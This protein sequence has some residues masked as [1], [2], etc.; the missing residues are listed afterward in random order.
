MSATAK[1][2]VGGMIAAGLLLTLLVALTPQH[3]SAGPGIWATFAALTLLATAS[4]LFKVEA[5]N[6]VLFYTTP[7]FLFAGVLLLPPVLIVLLVIIPY[8]VAWAKERLSNSPHYRAW[9]LQPFNMAMNSITGLVSYCLYT[10]LCMGLSG[11]AAT[12]GAIAGIAAAL[13]YVLIN[14]IILS[15]ALVLA[16]DI[17]WRETSLHNI[18][19]LLNDVVLN[20]LGL[21]VATLWGNHTLLLIP[22]LAPVVLMYQ[23]LMIPQLKHM[24][25][26]DS[27]TGLA[28]AGH[29]T[30]LFTAELHRATRFSRPLAV[31]MADLDL[32]RHVN[33]TYGHLAGDAVLA[34]IGQILRDTI[35]E[36]DIGGRFGGEEF[37]IVAPETDAEEAV[38]LAERLR[39]AVAEAHFAVPTSSQPL[40]VTM[41]LGVACY[42][43]DGTSTDELIFAADMAVYAAKT[44]GRN[45]VVRTSD[46]TWDQRVMQ[47]PPQ[48][49]GSMSQQSVTGYPA[50]PPIAVVPRNVGLADAP[51]SNE[52]AIPAVKTTD[53]A[54][55]QQTPTA[56]SGRHEHSRR[57][58]QRLS[59]LIPQPAIA[60]VTTLFA[61]LAAW[62]ALRGP[63]DWLGDRSIG[64]PLEAAAL[65]AAIV[66]AYQYPIHIRLHMKV[67]LS[68]MVY[69]WMAVLLPLPLAITAAALGTLAGE[70]S[71][72]TQRT[73][74]PSDI[75]TAASRWLL[76]VLLGNL[77]VHCNGG[78][79][80][81]VIL[82]AGAGLAL[83][84]GDCLTLP[85]IL[86]PITGEQPLRV[87]RTLVRETA[88]ADGIQYLLGF[89]GVL[90]SEQ[91]SWALVLF[92]VP[93]AL[94]Y[95][96][97]THLHN[98]QDSTHRL[99][100]CMA[101]TVDLR[102]PCTGGHSR[103]VETYCQRILG[104]LGICGPDKELIL[105]AARV[106]DIG[107]I[108]IPDSIL[109]KPGALT[110]TEFNMMKTHPGRGAE[111]LARHQDFVR[112]VA[113]VRHHHEAWNGSGYPHGLK[114]VAIPFGARVL[115]VAD[116]FDAMTS[117]RPYR[118]GMS[119]ARAASILRQGR[120]Q[121]WDP[122]IVDAL[123]RSTV[124]EL[125]NGEEQLSAVPSSLLP[126]RSVS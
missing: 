71:V 106:H 28:N 48:A 117:D 25:A 30:S 47:P 111:V 60:L 20:C 23:A 53:R 87:L 1:A 107:K 16:R 24:A 26:I 125:A 35:R 4:Q 51:E 62:S 18:S 43:V 32:L 21:I 121:Q 13:A 49:N 94:V 90:V 15:L 42:P 76:I 83:W 55:Q 8:L 63:V 29:F 123:L 108:G 66:V 79:R 105:S 31:I 57:I 12:A 52:T 77:I 91:A 122:D 80:P 114:G 84:G 126:A 120:G 39:S 101:D 118:P 45:A 95:Q 99:L 59:R 2:Y 89:L 72:R 11:N 88:T 116:S 96:A 40:S 5:P 92:A 61:L 93:A 115:A 78:A 19:S 36:Y 14:H 110:T 73:L 82:L 112:G 50:P 103:R 33:N 104:E 102:D 65:A 22:A 3:Y 6:H 70:V 58:W 9:Y 68:T 74:Y 109:N 34:G 119:A 113:I 46:L 85:L 54:K 81:D 37:T 67:Q 124:M 75:V 97:T 10:Q 17:P 44:G 100:E 27:K 38:L 7:I 98:V 56:G 64:S 69:Y 86:A 41:S